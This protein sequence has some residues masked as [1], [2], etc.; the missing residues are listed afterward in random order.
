AQEFVSEY[1]KAGKKAELKDDYTYEAA[2]KYMNVNKDVLHLSLKWISFN[3]LK[4]DKNAY[5]ELRQYMIETGLSKNP[6]AYREFVDNSLI[7]KVK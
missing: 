6:P 5:E 4:I 1:V 3:D 2:S 7:D